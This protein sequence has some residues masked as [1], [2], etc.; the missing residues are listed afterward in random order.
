MVLI[1]YDGLSNIKVASFFVFV[2]FFFVNWV[3]IFQFHTDE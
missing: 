1:L 3:V 2:D